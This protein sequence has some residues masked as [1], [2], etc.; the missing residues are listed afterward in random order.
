M[1]GRTLTVRPGALAVARLAPG[2]PAPAWATGG[3]AGIV[4]VVTTAGETSVVCD[5]EAV[6][7]GAPVSAG[8][9]ALVVAGPLDHGLT[10]VLASIADPLADAAV[11]I[12]AISTFDTDWVLVPGDRLDDAV[13]ALR[14]AG[15]RV[16]DARGG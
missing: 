14:A 2:S 8:W 13:A 11:P 3:P 4:A 6:P 7:G 15:H 9:R 16:D 5:A 10:G 1:P 12:F